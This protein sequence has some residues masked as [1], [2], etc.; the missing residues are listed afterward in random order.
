MLFSNSICWQKL[1]LNWLETEAPYKFQPNG[2]TSI[3][4]FTRRFTWRLWEVLLMRTFIFCILLGEIIDVVFDKTN[5]IPVLRSFSM[6]SSH[7]LLLQPCVNNNSKRY[8]D[9]FNYMDDYIWKM[10]GL[11]CGNTKSFYQ[12]NSD[13]M[14]SKITDCGL[15]NE[16]VWFYL[17]WTVSN[18]SK[19]KKKL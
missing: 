11:N 17:E 14:N 15:T 10:E 5:E 1:I 3:N 4:V 12:T 8:L 2:K 13:H 16:I 9:T 7:K 18:V 19:N 6:R